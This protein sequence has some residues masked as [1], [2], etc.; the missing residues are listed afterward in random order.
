MPLAIMIGPAGEF[1]GSLAVSVIL[2]ITSSLFLALT[3][4]PAMFG[5]LAGDVAQ[6]QWNIGLRVRWIER[7]FEMALIMLYV[8]VALSALVGLV[9]LACWIYTVIVAFTKD[10]AVIGVVCLCPIVGLVMGF[11][12]M[13]GSWC[14]IKLII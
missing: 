3:W 8:V 7:L 10:T 2:A 1:V 12:K 4:I 13:K 9:S 6:S 5:F 14:Y 11:I